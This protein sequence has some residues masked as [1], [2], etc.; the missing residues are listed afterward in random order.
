MKIDSK[1]YHSDEVA[2]VAE[3]VEELIQIL[4]E[5]PPE[6]PVNMVK[7]QMASGKN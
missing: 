2:P 6:L 5:L 4:K 7:Y 1:F 3:N